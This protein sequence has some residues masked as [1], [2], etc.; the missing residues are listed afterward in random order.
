MDMPFLR[1][2]AVLLACTVLLAAC[3]GDEQ[4]EP[5]EPL[6]AE[7]PVEDPAA[8]AAFERSYGECSS[9]SLRTLAA[10][11]HAKAKDDA[12]AAAVGKGWASRFNGG[13]SA[14][15]SGRDGCLQGLLEQAQAG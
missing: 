5:S 8:I 1:V 3:G 2:L 14:E 7:Q 12:V 13:P 15:R 11:Y 4:E 6:P 9:Y 10:K